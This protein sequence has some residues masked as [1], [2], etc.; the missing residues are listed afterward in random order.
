[1]FLFQLHIQFTVQHTVHTLHF[2][3]VIT[4]TGDP[5]F[6]YN[7]QCVEVPFLQVHAPACVCVGQHLLWSRQTS[8]KEQPETRAHIPAYTHES[9]IWNH[10]KNAS[11]V[12]V[13]VCVCQSPTSLC[14]HE[15]VVSQQLR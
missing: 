15:N 1:M 6:V 9:N 13:C 11:H 3:A 8:R 5:A 7:H 10:S 14:S 2:V 12:A 4:S